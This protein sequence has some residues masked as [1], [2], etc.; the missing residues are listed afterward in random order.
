MSFEI[1]YPRGK[2]I[3]GFT[4]CPAVVA[5]FWAGVELFYHLL[6]KFLLSKNWT[7]LFSEFF[8]ILW[9]VSAGGMVFYGIPAFLLALLYASLKLSKSL[10][11]YFLV[12]IAGG[13]GAQVWGGMFILVLNWMERIFE[14][15]WAFLM[16]AFSSLIIAIFVLPKPAMTDE[17]T[18]VE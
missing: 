4:L 5:S 9:V 14:F 3:F 13:V 7:E 2:V 12:F 18:S 10:K 11:N 17:G 16:G 6:P 8:M 1:K 15:P